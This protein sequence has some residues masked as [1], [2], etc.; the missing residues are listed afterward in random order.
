[1]L[2]GSSNV[3]ICY[4]VV[5]KGTLFG[6]LIDFRQY[7]SYYQKVIMKINY[8]TFNSYCQQKSFKTTVRNQ[9]KNKG[10]R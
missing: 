7:R 1:M 6:P 3:N 2:F 8:F 9:I 4:K 10:N 5:R